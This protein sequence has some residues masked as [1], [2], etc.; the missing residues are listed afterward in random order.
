M[1]RIRPLYYGYFAFEVVN[2][3]VPEI[4]DRSN[5][6]VSSRVDECDVRVPRMNSTVENDDSLAIEHC[7]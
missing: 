5:N 1:R 3:R 4:C 7:H 6:H 2:G